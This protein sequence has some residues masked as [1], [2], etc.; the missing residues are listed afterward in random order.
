MKP[1]G[2]CDPKGL[3]GASSLVEKL[4]CAVPLGPTHA[5]YDKLLREWMA[6]RGHASE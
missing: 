3:S 1:E 2:P 5:F 4:T 6:R